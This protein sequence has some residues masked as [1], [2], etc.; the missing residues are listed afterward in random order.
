M[1]IVISNDNQYIIKDNDKLLYVHKHYENFESNAASRY[2]QNKA[3]NKNQLLNR[4]K[5]RFLNRIKI[6]NSTKEI[7]NLTTAAQQEK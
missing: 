6:N 3:K 7:L 1:S 5:T 2:F 4:Y